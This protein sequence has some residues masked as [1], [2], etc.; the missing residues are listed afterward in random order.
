MAFARI[1]GWPQKLF[2]KIWVWKNRSGAYW[3]DRH[4]CGFA[5][6]W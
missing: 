4:G 3:R 1:N 2:P 6:L 5:V